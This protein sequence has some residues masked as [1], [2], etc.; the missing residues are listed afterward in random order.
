M[1]TSWVIVSKATGKPVMETFTKRVADAANRNFYDV[2][3]IGLW[4]ASLNRRDDGRNDLTAFKSCDFT[5]A[6]EQPLAGH[7]TT[8]LPL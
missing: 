6:P 4:L 2:L 7:G 3:P 1:T 8:C 5:L